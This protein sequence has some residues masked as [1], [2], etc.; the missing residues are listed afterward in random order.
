MLSLMMISDASLVDWTWM[1]APN[2]ANQE[3]YFFSRWVKLISLLTNWN[4]KHMEPKPRFWIVALKMLTK[5]ITNTTNMIILKKKKKKIFYTK[6]RR[7]SKKHGIRKLIQQWF[8]RFNPYFITSNGNKNFWTGIVLFIR[9]IIVCISLH[10]HTFLMKY[11]HGNE[12]I[13]ILF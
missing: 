11:I 10:W 4:L 5:K 13:V 6:K 9:I 7:W 3:N 8:I 1:F 12:E 2:L